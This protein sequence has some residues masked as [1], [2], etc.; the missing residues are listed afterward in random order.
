MGQSLFNKLLI[1]VN[2]FGGTHLLHCGLMDIPNH[3]EPHFPTDINRQSCYF[4]FQMGN[5]D[6]FTF[7]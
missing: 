4:L 7:S 6:D 3:Y 2:A 1:K 5:N